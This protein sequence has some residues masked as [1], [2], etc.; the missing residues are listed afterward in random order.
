MDNV[1]FPFGHKIVSIWTPFHWSLLLTF[2]N[3]DSLFFQIWV[4]SFFVIVVVSFVLFG[5][6]TEHFSSIWHTFSLSFGV[7]FFLCVGCYHFKYYRGCCFFFC[8]GGMRYIFLR[9]WIFL[10]KNMGL[11]WRFEDSSGAV[12]S[13][14]SMKYLNAFKVQECF[15]LF[16]LSRFSI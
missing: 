4:V 15:F 13:L 7:E 3:Y 10:K 9:E 11:F 2:P 8:G 6:V 12:V 5:I 1:L 16:I 14:K